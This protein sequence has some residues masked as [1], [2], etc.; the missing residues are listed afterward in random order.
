MT[1]DTT[2]NIIIVHLRALR[3]QVD[4]IRDDVNFLKEGQNSLRNQVN[5]LRG[6]LLRFEQRTEKRLDRIESRLSLAD[7]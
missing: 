2:D 3:D 6:D 5:E 4:G 7:A 1:T